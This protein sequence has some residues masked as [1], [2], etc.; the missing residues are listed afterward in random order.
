MSLKPTNPTNPTIAKP[1]ISASLI[2]QELLFQVAVAHEF[3]LRYLKVFCWARNQAILLLTSRIGLTGETCVTLRQTMTTNPPSADRFK[4][5]G[6]CQAEALPTISTWFRCRVSIWTHSFRCN[7]D[8]LI[9]DFSKKRVESEKHTNVLTLSPCQLLLC[10]RVEG[11]VV[12]NPS[13]L[14]CK[15]F[16]KARKEHSNNISCSL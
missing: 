10:C 11:R 9:H 12:A 15:P 14:M 8:S 3:Y 2:P 13:I 4:D 5:G 1:G 16:Q 7:L 6:V